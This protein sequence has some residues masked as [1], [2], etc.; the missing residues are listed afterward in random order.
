[1]SSENDPPPP[2]PSPVSAK[3]SKLQKFPHILNR[4]TASSSSSSSNNEIIVDEGEEEKNKN[5]NKVQEEEDA[6]VFV[7]RG[8]LERA[9]SSSSSSSSILLQASSLGLN[10]IRT[11]FS[12]PLRH[13]SSAGA[14]TFAAVP[15][16]INNVAKSR[17]K[18]SYPK[19]L[20]IHI[21]FL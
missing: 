10:Q 19:D 8:Q 21:F 12:S 2:T 4:H 7:P 9:E 11:R 5:K 13:S 3:S 1:M 20:G 18:S 14:P 15:V 17:S 6:V 16:N